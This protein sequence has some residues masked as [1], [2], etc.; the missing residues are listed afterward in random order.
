MAHACGCVG[1]CVGV[2][3]TRSGMFDPPPSPLGVFSLPHP[4]KRN[5]ARAI[6]TCVW[7]VEPREP[8]ARAC[9]PNER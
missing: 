3:N 2:S 9:A 6:E 1:V 8:G 7:P 5:H 4:H